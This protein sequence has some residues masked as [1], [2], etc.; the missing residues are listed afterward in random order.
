MRTGSSAP[1]SRTW[2]G[3]EGGRPFDGSSALGEGVG[4]PSRRSRCRGRGVVRRNAILRPSGD[5]AGLVQ[6]LASGSLHRPPQKACGIGS[7]WSPLPSLWT[8]Q[9]VLWMAESAGDQENSAWSGRRVLRRGARAGVKG[10]RRFIVRWC[11]GELHRDAEPPGAPGGEGEGSLVCS[12][13]ALD[14]G[15]AEADAWVVGAYALGAAQKRLG[16][17]GDQLW[18]ELLAGVLDG[19]HHILG[20]NGGRDPHGALSRKVVDDRVVHEVRSHLKQEGG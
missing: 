12:G 13:D 6:P 11:G 4:A 16:E 14:D 2:S 20:V 19:E 9:S 17:R 3:L 7:W 18:G 15:Q 5:Q 10:L 8:T 1:T